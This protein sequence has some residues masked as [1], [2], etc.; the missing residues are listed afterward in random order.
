MPTFTSQMKVSQ[1]LLSEPKFSL[2][3]SFLVPIRSSNGIHHSGQ[4][5]KAHGSGKECKYPP[6]P[7]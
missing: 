1:N 2:F 7:R 6:V 3:G 5:D 4:G